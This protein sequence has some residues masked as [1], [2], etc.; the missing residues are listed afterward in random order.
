MN[1]FVAFSLLI[2]LSLLTRVCNAQ[3]YYK[4]LIVNKE[5]TARWRSCKDNHVKAVTLSSLEADGKPTDGFTGDQQVSADYLHVT[6]HSKSSGTGD[7]WIF[8]DYSPGGQGLVR[9]LDTSDTYQ[10]ESVYQYDNQG[11]LTSISDTSTETDNHVTA[12]EQHIWTYDPAHP[13]K[14]LSMLKIVN[15]H[16]TTY[17]R[18]VLDDNGNVT[19][20]R[21][22][23]L[24]VALP[25][26]YYY[27][28]AGNHLTDIVRY[29]ARA[30]RLLPVEMFE[31]GEDG[32][33]SS[34]LI[35]PEEGNSF[36]EKWYYEYNDK[37]LKIKDFCYN[38]QKELLGSVEYRY[39]Y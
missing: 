6:T 27:Y 19:E 24:G 16:D 5:N 17:I 10:N 33:V 37:G 22:T 32:K 12:V 9:N 7:S 28:D 26:F 15:G 39:T 8:A 25:A 20:E 13:G 35:V 1:R 2:T 38:K 21:S 11:R 14:P 31:Y 18:F 23:R 36:Y 3:Y 29:N 30:A 4:D 34:A